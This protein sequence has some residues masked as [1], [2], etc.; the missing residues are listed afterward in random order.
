MGDV[1][2]GTV[3]CLVG[4]EKCPVSPSPHV[5][6]PCSPSVLNSGRVG[7]GQGTAWSAQGRTAGFPAAAGPGGD[8][9]QSSTKAAGAQSHA[10][11]LAV[12]KGTG[13][14][15][16][17]W[18]SHPGGAWQSPWW[19]PWAEHSCHWYLAVSSPLPGADPSRCP[20]WCRTL[21]WRSSKGITGAC[22]T[23]Q[24]LEHPEETSPSHCPHLTSMVWGPCSRAG[25]DGGLWH[26]GCSQSPLSG[27]AVHWLDLG[28]SRSCAWP[29]PDLQNEEAN[30]SHRQAKGRCP[31]CA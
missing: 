26:S 9:A 13:D 19:E 7:H 24:D 30:A 2:S 25:E 3:V 20:L 4:E 15:S 22:V 1:L 28:N 5:R 29:H 18:H 8:Q 27:C 10:T 16:T 31:G 11:A 23:E 14:V 17:R 6:K 21:T 12:R